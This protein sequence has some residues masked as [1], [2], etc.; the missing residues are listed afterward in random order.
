ALRA[1]AHVIAAAGMGQRDRRQ[2]TV[3]QEGGGGDVPAAL[4]GPTI[5]TWPARGAM[6]VGEPHSAGAVVLGLGQL[7]G[8]LLAP[9]QDRLQVGGRLLPFA[10]H[11]TP[12][13][14]AARLVQPGA[15]A[16]WVEVAGVLA[17]LRPGLV[18][19][20][21]QS[22]SLITGQANMGTVQRRLLRRQHVTERR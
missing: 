9:R 4:G 10:V 18:P 13:A 16:V 19:G 5:D 20:S 6:A 14:D 8:L 3:A 2:P 15:F 1:E 22:A 11:K 21:P 12:D 7:V 17:P